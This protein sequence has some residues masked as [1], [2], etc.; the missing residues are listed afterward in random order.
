M[1]KAAYS[2]LNF[3]SFCFLDWLVLLYGNKTPDRRH[4]T[5]ADSHSP[6]KDRICVLKKLL[7]LNI[8]CAAVSPIPT[9]N[10]Q[11][12]TQKILTALPYVDFVIIP[13]F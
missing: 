4:K 8:A 2:H 9:V 7:C 1:A 12:N 11:L 10:I 5:V 13:L 3:V 6:G